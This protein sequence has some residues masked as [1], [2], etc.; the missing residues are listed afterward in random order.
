MCDTF[1]GNFACSWSAAPDMDEG[2]LNSVLNSFTDSMRVAGSYSLQFHDSMRYEDLEM[3]NSFNHFNLWQEIHYT[4]GTTMPLWVANA[5]SVVQLPMP[6]RLSGVQRAELSALLEFY[7]GLFSTG[8]DDYGVV[9]DDMSVFHRI[10]TGDAEPVARRPYRLSQHENEWLRGHVLSLQEKGIVRPSNSPWMAP[11]VLVKKTDGTLRFCCDLRALNQVTLKDPLTMP[12]IDECC[13]RM[14]GH[15]FY[16]SVD[17]VS[18]FWHIPL[19]PESI[20]KTGFSTPFGNWE[21]LRMPFGLCNASAPFQRFM[22]D[23]IACGFDF[24]SIYLDNI[25]VFS[26]TW[27]EHLAHLR[28]VLDRT[29]AAGLKLKLSKCAFAATSARCLGFIVDAHGIH[30]DPAKVGAIVNLPVPKDMP[31][32]RSLLG[33][34]GFYSHHIPHFAETARCL[35]LLTRKGIQFLW[36]PECDKAFHSLKAALINA[37]VLRPPDWGRDFLL[38]TDWSKQA[39]GAVLSQIDEA[40]E[41]HP[42]AFASRALTPSEQNYAATE[43]EC[44]ALVWATFQVPSLFGRQAFHRAD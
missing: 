19:H 9:P 17:V 25:D 7:D 44:P 34:A 6:S 15:Q 23:H 1:H 20:V 21:W 32:V 31:A 28:V 39:V 12:R 37:P 40:G 4:S 5:T 24:V 22:N 16:S 11:P 2:V 3:C 10:L 26:D 41:E 38:T 35:Q 27:E 30:T 43:G 42:V 13:T 18:A 36:S 8:P 29:A 33:M 14:A